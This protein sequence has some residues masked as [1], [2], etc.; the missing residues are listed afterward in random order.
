MQIGFPFISRISPLPSLVAAI[1]ERV[2]SKSARLQRFSTVI[3]LVTS[4]PVRVADALVPRSRQRKEGGGNIGN[5]GGGSFP[6]VRAR[7][8]PSVQAPDKPPL[9]AV[10]WTGNILILVFVIGFG[11]WSALAPLKSAAIAPG[12]V[13]PESSRKTIQHLEGGIVREIL[14]KNGEAVSAGQVLIKLDDTK[15]RAEFNALRGQIWDAEARRAR[16]ASEQQDGDRVDFPASLVMLARTDPAVGAILSG[17]R[18]IFEARRQVTRSRIAITSQKMK[19]VQQEI[20]GLDAQQKALAVR[21]EI[22]RQQIDTISPLVTKGLERKSNLL[23]LNQQKAD[24]EGQLGETSAQI[25]RAYQVISEA[26]ADLVKIES[27]RQNEI[28]QELRDADSQILQLGDRL[29]AI[30]DQLMRTDVK[31]PQDGVVVGLRIHTTGGVIGAGEPLL[32]LMPAN[33]RLIVSVHVRPEDIALVHPGL[34]AQV[35]LLPYNQRRVPL[36]QAEVAYVS[37]DRLED[38]QSGQP[39]YAATIRVMDERVTKTHEIG[40]LSGMPAQALIET[41]QSSVALY[42]LQPLL[43]SFHSAFREN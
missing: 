18:R 22:I 31:A 33:D 28:A 2:Q 7:A 32:D 11:L 4:L 20:V 9:R 16:F 13:E 15:P 24:L 37:A 5:R 40:M 3:L 21:A 27:D 42:M 10:A 8:E 12:V 17:Q 38:K 35:H 30:D 14:V 6:Q 1:P 41:G 36:L 25:A 26:Q 23:N 43:D 19:Q 29:Q 39:Y 34:H